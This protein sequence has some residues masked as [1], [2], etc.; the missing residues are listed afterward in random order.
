ME[1]KELLVNF[2]VIPADLVPPE[3]LQRKW[4]V[5]VQNWPQVCFGVVQ[6]LPAGERKKQQLLA[7]RFFGN[8]T[9]LAKGSP[10]PAEPGRW[11]KMQRCSHT[12]EQRL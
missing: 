11:L 4:V 3:R 7:R 8:V 6:I 1:F 12:A 5:L 2:S 9:R 10:V